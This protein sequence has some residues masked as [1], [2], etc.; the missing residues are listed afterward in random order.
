MCKIISLFQKIFISYWH[1]ISNPPFTFKIDTCG[2]ISE[3]KVN[4]EDLSS[5]YAQILLILLI[6][7]W[8]PFFP[9][10]KKHHTNPNDIILSMFRGFCCHHFRNQ[11]N[12]SHTTKDGVTKMAKADTIAAMLGALVVCFLSFTL[13]CSAQINLFLSTQ[14]TKQII[15]EF[16][17][18]SH[19]LSDLAQAWTELTA[20]LSTRYPFRPESKKSLVYTSE[21]TTA[22]FLLNGQIKAS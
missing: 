11:N 10:E 22:L 18:S 21:I 15:G 9:P 19:V 13:H 12:S 5:L 16:K 4:L 17:L 20:I 1:M 8:A 7:L 2:F 3:V 6:L 14:Q